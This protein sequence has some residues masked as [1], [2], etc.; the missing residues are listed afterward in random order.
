MKF[1]ESFEGSI[2]I[3]NNEV[4]SGDQLSVYIYDNSGKLVRTLLK[5][6][7]LEENEIKL[8]WDGMSDKGNEAEA[9]LY[10]L[11]FNIN[12]SLSHQRI[13]KN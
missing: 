11:S 13:I 5:N 4:H 2:N 9:G 1:T 3:Y 8:V 12:G 6:A 10:H 7:V